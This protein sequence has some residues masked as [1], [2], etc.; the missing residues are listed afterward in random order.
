MAANFDGRDMVVTLTFDD[1]HL[2]PDK[3]K[4]RELFRRFER[5][6]R[7]A[8]KRR[9]EELKRILVVEGH[10][11]K[12]DEWIFGEDGHLEDKRIHL[13]LVING[14]NKRCIEEIRSLWPYGGYIRAE[15][16]DVHYYRELAKYLTKEAREFARP[17]PGEQTWSCS[18]NLAAPKIEYIEVPDSVTLCPPDGAVDYT[19]Y[20]EVN[21]Y[22][23]GEC[24][25]ARYLMPPREAPPSYAGKPLEN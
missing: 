24:V 6:L 16:I 13:H 10:H 2:P 12:S 14:N 25:V 4:A 7:A 17:K 1:E 21:P 18:K 5:K 22:G 9:G 11:G 8:R 20:H 15:R 3:S 23:Y 19:Q